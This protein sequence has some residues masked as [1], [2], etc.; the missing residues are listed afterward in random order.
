[1]PLN[2]LELV[3]IENTPNAA[4]I[5]KKPAKTVEFP[6]S[7]DVLELIEAMKKKVIEIDGVGL[8]ANQVGHH[9][10]VIVYLVPENAL[11]YRVDAREEV[12]LTVL[13]NPSYTPIE[14][15]GKFAD[16]EGCFSVAET[17][18]KVN[19]YKSIHYEGQTIDGKPVKTTAQ[20]F[21][22]RVLQHEIDHVN[23]FLI[24]D[25]LTPDCIQGN[26]KEMIN[27]RKME[28]EERINQKS[29]E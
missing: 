15:D 5:L 13:I 3:T 8:A 6:L 28:Y 18:G 9:L 24:V 27:I 12:P 10:R 22:A 20:G 4:E 17:V 14:A 2:P 25:R 29:D 23:G 7:A 19:R 16:W 1:M 26:P 11:S 21:L